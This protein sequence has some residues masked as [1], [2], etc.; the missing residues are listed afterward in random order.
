M[1]KN[2]KTG[3]KRV[4]KERILDDQGRKMV[5]KK[6]GH[7][8]EQ[9]FNHYNGFEEEQAGHFD[10]RWENEARDMGFYE[11]VGS[12]L[13]YKNGPKAVHGTNKPPKKTKNVRSSPNEE[14]I[15]SR[16]LGMPQP[17]QKKAQNEEYIQSR[18]LGMPQPKQK[19]A[20]N[21]EYI[22]S[23]GLGMPEPKAKRNSKMDNQPYFANTADLQGTKI[24]NK[25]N[26]N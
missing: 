3:E 19:R 25:R 24:P 11:G 16:G 15:E 18:G 21:E 1:Y 9:I 4:A 20:S 8:D 12:M 22:E 14:Y 6:L 13:G 5:R 23:R 10:N 7:G 17:K 2:S 26:R